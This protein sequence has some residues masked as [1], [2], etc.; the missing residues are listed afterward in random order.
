MV[1]RVRR[2][3][4]VKPAPQRS[5]EG[6]G[7]W[8]PTLFTTPFPPA[9]R[10]I[11]TQ[12]YFGRRAIRVF[13]FQIALRPRTSL[14]FST[15]PVRPSAMPS[16]RWF[17]CVVFP[18]PPSILQTS[19]RATSCWG[20]EASAPGSSQVNWTTR[21]SPIRVSRTLAIPPGPAGARAGTLVEGS[22]SSLAKAER[23]DVRN[24][25]ASCKIGKHTK[26]HLKRL[27]R[28]LEKPPDTT[29]AVC[30]R[31]GQPRRTEGTVAAPAK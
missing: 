1:A 21:S 22:V 10:I 25:S 16:D 23:S 11:C 5:D 24:S 18:A 15:S 6:S 19:L 13:F 3:L 29:P 4:P 31:G 28:V 26:R 2:C 9:Y 20:A 30:G 12:R 7:V 8:A 27:L 17:I 14:R